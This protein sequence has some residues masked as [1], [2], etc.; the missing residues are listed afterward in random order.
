[1]HIGK[2]K[3]EQAL[4]HALAQGLKVNSNNPIPHICVP[5]V[6]GKQHCDLFL[7]KVSNCSKTPFEHIH[8]DLHEVLCLTSSSYCCWLTFINNCLRYACIYLLK[9]KSKAL[10]AF[11]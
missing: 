3:I 8:S 2:A 9:R 4:K 6:H 1:V 10:N 7:A 5:C 11:K